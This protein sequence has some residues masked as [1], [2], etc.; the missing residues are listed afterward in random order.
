MA[1]IDDPDFKL[2]LEKLRYYRAESRHEYS[3]MLT[4]LGTYMTSQSFLFIAYPSAM[5]TTIAG[6]AR[7]SFYFPVLLCILG[8]ILSFHAYPGLAGASDRI[9]M[10]RDMEK[11]LFELRQ[12]T[13]G[14]VTVVSVDPDLAD[15]RG[16]PRPLSA[17]GDRKQTTDVIY[18]R[19][20]R[21]ARA[22]PF[23]FGTSWVLL[24]LLTV[25]L[26]LT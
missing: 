26:H 22:T 5:G 6:D 25:Y 3:L 24:E 18:V 2:K 19:G 15:F 9:D 21:F 14:N 10:W 1:N 20:L 4:R 23:I 13:K 16:E 17:E 11:K 8:F 12:Q 7:F